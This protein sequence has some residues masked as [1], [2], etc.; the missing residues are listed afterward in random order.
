MRAYREMPDAELFAS[1]WVTVTIP[2]EDL[3]G[4]KGARVSCDECGEAIAFAREVDRG[5]RRLCRSCAG[6]RY[7]RPA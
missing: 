1:Q 6:A 5:G 4:Y 2:P 3:P 7:Y